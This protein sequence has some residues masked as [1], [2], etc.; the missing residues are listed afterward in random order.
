MRKPLPDIYI[1]PIRH[2]QTGNDNNHPIKRKTKKKTKIN[3]ITFIN[4]SFRKSTHF[5]CKIYI[6]YLLY[7]LNYMYN[8]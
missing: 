4:N 2:R 6:Y 1:Y 7:N 5:I 3:L 8:I